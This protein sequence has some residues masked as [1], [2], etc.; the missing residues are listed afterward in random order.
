MSYILHFVQKYQPSAAEDFFKLEAEFKNL[1]R[2]SPSFPQGRRFQLLSD[3]QPTNTMVWEGEFASL[4]DVQAALQK[5]AD[6]PTHTRLFEK[7]LPYIVEMRTEI[8]QLLEL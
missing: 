6:D 5:L 3:G 4:D 8:Y 2:C 1:E 7:Q